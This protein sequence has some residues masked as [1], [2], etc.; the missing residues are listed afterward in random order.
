[1][2]VSYTHLDVY[3]RQVLSQHEE[4]TPLVFVGR[5]TRISGEMLEHAL[6][7]VSYTHLVM[8]PAGSFYSIQDTDVEAV[9]QLYKEE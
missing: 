6:I 8:Q 4:E 7:P 9:R 1:M 5:D 3:K 2:A